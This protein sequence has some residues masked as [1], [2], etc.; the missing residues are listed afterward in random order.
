MQRLFNVAG[1][2]FVL[3]IFSTALG[4]AE[5]VDSASNGFNIELEAFIANDPQNV[6][7]AFVDEVGTWW[8]PAHTFSGDSSNLSIR[9]VPN[10]C[11]CEKFVDG[12]GTRHMTVVFVEPGKRIN[13]QGGLGPLQV[14]AATGSM[15][16]QFLEAGPGTQ[17]KFSYRVAGYMQN[18]LDALAE[19][20]DSVLAG[21]LDRFKRYVETGSPR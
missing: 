19:V 3:I 7:E 8:D 13:M 16:I 10:G 21:Q 14:M 17:V 15:S 5:V 1:V 2:F 12:G 20:V 18:G 9:A 6:F 11:F 4:R